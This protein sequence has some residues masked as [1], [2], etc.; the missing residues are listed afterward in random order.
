M[1]KLD[2]ATW[3]QFAL[4][5]YWLA[6]FVATHVPRQFSAL[7]REGTDKLVHIAAFAVLAWL[8]A[9]AWEQSVG[10]LRGAH[11]VAIGCLLTV[12]A[13]FDEA[14]Q[15]LVGRTASFGDWLADGIG[16]VVG[17][18]AFCTWRPPL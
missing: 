14:T 13:A 4:A 10:R 11:L 2:C 3:W 5:G 7:P 9:T 17:L 15:P 8:L 16:V 1:F 12:Y 6:M 18:I